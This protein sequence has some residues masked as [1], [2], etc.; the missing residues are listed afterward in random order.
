MQITKKLATGFTPL[1]LALLLAPLASA[2]LLK[3][4]QTEGCQVRL[5]NPTTQSWGDPEPAPRGTIIDT[6]WGMG[7]GEGWNPVSA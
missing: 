6:A 2:D 5:W 7:W 3:C 1:V 4:V